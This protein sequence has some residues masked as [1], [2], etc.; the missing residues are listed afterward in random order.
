[1]GIYDR[2]YYRN[3]EPLNKRSGPLGIF[4]WSAVATIITIN[5][6]LFF[7]NGLLYPENN[8]LTEALLMKS[9]AL[10]HPLQWYTLI[11]YGFAHSP[12]GFM[13]ILFNM[14]GLFM[15]GPPVE[16]RYGKKEFFLFYFAALF[17]GGL[18]WGLFNLNSNTG[19]LGASGAVTAVVILFILNYP[20]TYLYLFGVIPMPAWLA[21]LL[22]VGLDMFGAFGN[23]LPGS[24]NIAHDVHLSGAAFALIYFFAKVRFSSIFSI[25][26]FR[27]KPKIRIYP[28]DPIGFR[29]DMEKE[30]D[31]LLRKINDHGEESLTREERQTLR[32]ASRHYQDRMQKK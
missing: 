25:S 6:I 8:Q 7:T 29:S 23:H 12:I 28:A 16:R 20:H 19:M 31:R 21:G 15:L 26:H 3:D 1:M 4:S 11:T 30:V 17:I 32:E 13:H 14:L 5:V 18:I 2:D 22:F 24:G 27:R 10:K 9:G